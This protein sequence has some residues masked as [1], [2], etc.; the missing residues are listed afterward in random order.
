MGWLAKLVS[1]RPRT[2]IAVIVLISLA[3]ASLSAVLEY[4]T[5]WDAW[6]PDTPEIEAID[7]IDQ[8]FGNIEYAEIL[9]KAPE[10]DV[11]TQATMLEILNLTKTLQEDEEVGPMLSKNRETISI[12]GIIADYELMA[13]NPSPTID[14][15]LTQIN[16][17]DDVSIKASLSSFLDDNNIPQ[18]QKDDVLLTLSKDYKEAGTA[19]ATGIFLF[20]DRS[21]GIDEARETEVKIEELVEAFEQSA[22]SEMSVYGDLL[23]DYYAEE[24][25]NQFGLVLVVGLIGTV[26]LGY[27]NFRRFSDIVLTG[28]GLLFAV[29]WSMGFAYLM[30]WKLDA[31]SMMVPILLLGLGIDYSIHTL[32]QYREK[33]QNEKD[34]KKAMFLAIAAVS[35]PLFLATITTVIGFL[36][37]VSSDYRA[38]QHFGIIAAVG[39][40][41]CFIVMNTFVPAVRL[42]LD[43][44]TVKNNKPLKFADYVAKKKDNGPL[45]RVGE[46]LLGMP[47]LVI[48]VTLILAGLGGYGATK[49][50]TNYTEIGDLPRN[51]ETKQAFHYIS[52]EFDVQ[53]TEAMTI[54]VKGDVLDPLVIAS[55]YESVDNMRDDQ[56]IQKRDSIPAIEWILPAMNT[57]AN[58]GLDPEFTNIYNE[59]DKNNDGV[60]DSP[61][62]ENYLLLVDNMYDST[63]TTEFFIYKNDEGQYNKLVLRVHT[64]T[65]NFRYSHEVIE[66]LE[67]DVEP[68][69]EMADEVIVTGLATIF[70]L[71]NINIKNS[72]IFSTIYCAIAALVVLTITFFIRGRSLLLGLITTI[73]V[74]LVVL[75]TYGTLKL[76]GFPLNFEVALIGALTIALGIDYSIHISHRIFTEMQEGS[77]FITSYRNTIKHTGRNLLFSASTTAFV[78]LCMILLNTE[79]TL[80]FGIAGAIMILY[81]FIASVIVLPTIL[82]L[83]IRF[84]SRKIW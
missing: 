34:L 21:K 80:Q 62:R 5:G 54:L 24:I 27:L 51:S 45:L 63:D 16:Q 23:V 38:V 39:I 60:M 55:I 6:M 64:K 10:D 56:Y 52:T 31:M 65:D 19:K 78:F 61:T 32:M 22:S 41:S 36:S 82:L 26:I 68:I 84:I 72:S 37:N 46:R 48:I 42:L 57:Y 28:I 18:Q 14:D 1:S 25:I 73:P 4:E 17:M 3:M 30:G 81:S 47:L 11:L 76:F 35:V 15:Q 74:I 44:R 8:D 83:R 59:Y 20:I 7:E 69:R 33:Y 70:D 53:A 13:T 58:S 49:L 66:E 9:I 40:I 29:T 75:W 2:V 77:D 67:E 12:A 79:G 50:E 71:Q 43:Q